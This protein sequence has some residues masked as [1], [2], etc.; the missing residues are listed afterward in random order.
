[1]ATYL[2]PGVY[3]E[4]L[5]TGPRP[6]AGVATSTAAFVG[7]SERG[8]VG[9]ARLVT[10]L[11]EF[12]QRFGGAIPV[13]PGVSEHYL[14]YSVRNFFESGGSRCY[15]VRVAH[16][17][18]ISDP[19][20]LEATAATASF[21]AQTLAGG[22]VAN[23]LTVSAGSPGTWGT[24]I[25]VR[26]RSTSK[27][28]VQLAENI[29]AGPATAVNLAPNG[30]VV[31]GSVLYL[32][33]EIAGTVVSVDSAANSVT[34]TTPLTEGGAISTRTITDGA[35]VFLPDFSL[36][37]QTNLA[38]PVDLNAANPPAAGALVLDDI[39][40]IEPG[41]SLHVAVEQ[42]LA[43]VS[44]VE[45]TTVAGQPAQRAV[46]PSTALPVLLQS[47]SRAYARDF[48][49]DVLLPSPSSPNP[50]T[51]ETHQNLSLAEANQLDHVNRRLGPDS[52]ASQYIV[53]AEPSPATADDIVMP[54]SAPTQLGGTPNDGL[55]NLSVADFEGSALAKNGLRSLDPVTDASILVVPPQPA[56]PVDQGLLTATAINYVEQRRSLFYIVDPEPTA[57]ADPVA[58]VASFRAGLTATSYAGLYFPWIRIPNPLT[59][60][61]L[62]VPP[63]GAVAGIFARSDRRRGVHKAPQLASGPKARLASLHRRSPRGAR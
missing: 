21:A 45:E 55:T 35:T 30:D 42:A 48:A 14:Y 38:A 16:Y 9:E 51:V 10:S 8:P 4:E 12:E 33:H 25:S 39:S 40:G 44:S 17:T 61:P 7:V 54:N 52:G 22:A 11:A 20:T 6:I 13:Q 43:V 32:V 18:N 27:F 50:V 58:A 15:V 63:S 1:M 34:F 47:A 56:P 37:T 49:L 60:L 23:A 31:P 36:M 46:I 28:Q 41:D 5:S 2:A 3:V 62:S 26:I 59:G 53:A 57:G 19:S 29:A 24:D